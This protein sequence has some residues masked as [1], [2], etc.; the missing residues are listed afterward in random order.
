MSPKNLAEQLTAAIA[1]VVEEA[2]LYLE[3]VNVSGPAKRSLVTVVVDLPEGPGGVDSTQVADVSR[4]ISSV[5]DD[6]DLIADAYTLEVSTP[7]AARKLTEP[8]HF[9]RAQGRMLDLTLASG[10]G[11][12]GRLSA[13]DGDNLVIRLEATKKKPAEDLTIPLA[14]ISSARVV[15]ELKQADDA[16]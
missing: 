13:L 3:K 8:R 2:G 10:E 7:G 5:L 1:P 15:V 6:A 11:L 9:S 12:K 4:A 14:E 16:S